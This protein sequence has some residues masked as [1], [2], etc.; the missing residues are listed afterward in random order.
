MPDQGEWWTCVLCRREKSPRSASTP[1]Y[2]RIAEDKVIFIGDFCG[3]CRPG[4]V[5]IAEPMK[6]FPNV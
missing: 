3:Q 4:L 1:L 2:E 5:A 6:E